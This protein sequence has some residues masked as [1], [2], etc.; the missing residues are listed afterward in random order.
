MTLGPE[1]GF[2]MGTEVGFH[3][4]SQGQD[5]ELG[6]GFGTE[7]GIGVNFE[8]WDEGRGRYRDGVRVGAGVGVVFWVFGWISRWGWG[9]VWDWGRGRSQVLGLGSELG[10]EIEVEVGVM[11]HIGGKKN[12]SRHITTMSRN[13]V[14]NIWSMPWHASL[15]CSFP[16][17]NLF[18][19]SVT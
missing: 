1:S 19:H 16:P 10:F 3:N 9:R 8:F 2:E 11:P 5:S 7:V 14:D 15:T 17:T 18:T 6:S 4:P 12:G 13:V